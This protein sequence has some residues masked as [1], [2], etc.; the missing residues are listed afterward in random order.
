M[1]A[2]VLEVDERMLAERRRLGLDKWDEMWEG[3]LHMVPPA[4]ERHQGLEA[5]LLVALRPSARRRG[6]KVRTDTGVF[7]SDNDYRVPD[8]V[9]YSREAASQRGVDGAPEIVVEIRSPNDETYEKV[10]WYLARG[11]RAVL[12]VDRDVLALQLFTHS[13]P[14]EP[15]GDGPIVLEPLGVE[16]A[17]SGQTLF[18]DAEAL[19]L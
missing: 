1:R 15:A 9:V 18:V 5:E 16:V 3:V 2:I 17:R 14:A 8:V 13:P 11:A 6:W 4:S 10:P 12:V 19:E 7:A